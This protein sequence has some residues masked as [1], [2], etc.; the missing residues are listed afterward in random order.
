MAAA[1]E[2]PVRSTL[3]AAG[4]S[5]VRC[6][7]E[8]RNVGLHVADGVVLAIRT[9]D[10]EFISHSQ[11]EPPVFDDPKSYT[12]RV[13]SADMQLDS[14]SL[15][16]LLQQSLKEHPAPISDVKVT[17][18]GGKMQ[19]AGKLKKGVTVPF[20]MTATVSSTPEGLLRLH[21]EKL[22]AVGVPVKG[23]L[24]LLGLNVDDLMKMPPGSGL[25]AEKDDLLMD[26]AVMLPP[27]KTEGRLQ[28]AEIVGDRLHLRMTGPGA[29][30]ARPSTLP[31]PSSKNYLYFFG[32]SIRFG[33]LTMSD[34]DLQLIDADP[35][36]P[37]DFFPAKYEAQL[38]AGYSHN[39]KR[40][41]LQVFMPDYAKTVGGGGTLPRPKVQ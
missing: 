32:G 31:L 5:P 4:S 26:A 18:E 19:A 29:P 38:I 23:L 1:A 9:L 22:K 12:L 14:A 25:R 33:K 36:T 40:K 41:G 27:P 35:K 7:I 10:G 6:G 37:F 24:D 13:K 15:T 21:A 17:I 30:P 11:S 3:E 8:M 34:A 16:N 20:T 39:T 28:S 2:L